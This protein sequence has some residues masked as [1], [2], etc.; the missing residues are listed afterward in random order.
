M[1]EDDATIANELIESGYLVA[2]DW[3]GYLDG[4]RERPDELHLV[5]VAV[6]AS[7]PGDV[8]EGTVV[9]T[10]GAGGDLKSKRAAEKFVGAV[11][12]GWEKDWW[13][14]GEEGLRRDATSELQVG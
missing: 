13:R 11:K 6:G 10:C 14:G 5:V 1:S 7:L 2:Q 4:L 8:Q 9:W 12:K 3:N